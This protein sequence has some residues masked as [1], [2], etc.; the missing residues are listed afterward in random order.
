MQSIIE[1]HGTWRISPLFSPRRANSKVAKAKRAFAALEEEA[2]FLLVTYGSDESGGWQQ[3]DRPLRTITTVDRFALVE[4]D[5]ETWRM[6][7]LQAPELQR[8]MGHSDD[9]SLLVGIRRDRGIS[10]SGMESAR[11]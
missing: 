7:M 11:P 9:F 8:P 6:R 1:Y 4:H 10:C 5:G 2:S 3:L